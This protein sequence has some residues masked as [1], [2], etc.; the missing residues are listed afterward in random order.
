MRIV[1]GILLF[2]A[3]ALHLLSGI[4]SIARSEAE[5]F[6]AREAHMAKTGDLSDVSGDLVDEE[7]REQERRSIENVEV[8]T[9]AATRRMAVGIALL[10]LAA[11]L[12]LAGV[13]VLRGRVGALALTIVGLS[14]AAGVADLALHGLNPLGASG[15]GVLAVAL[16]LALIARARASTTPTT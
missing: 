3:A 10:V 13:Q 6:L 9:S 15:P 4:G 1:A 16:V 5:A 11:A 7:T 2:I 14:L 8:D 12:L